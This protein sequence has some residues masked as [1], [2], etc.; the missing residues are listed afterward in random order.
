MSINVNYGYIGGS[1]NVNV[2]VISFSKGVK[3]LIFMNSAD[4]TEK[5]GFRRLNFLSFSK[6]FQRIIK[7]KK[8]P[9]KSLNKMR[10]IS[11][12]DRTGDTFCNVN[13][14]IG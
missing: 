3:C 8:I 2:D 7:V 4:F 5:N 12:V 1:S 11:S 13:V 10:Y 14:D 9:Q 6:S